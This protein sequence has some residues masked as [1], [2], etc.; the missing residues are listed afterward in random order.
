MD[1]KKWRLDRGLTQ[2]EAARLIGLTG[3]SWGSLE[4]GDKKLQPGELDV[5][6]ALTVVY[7]SGEWDE[8]NAK[9]IRPADI[10]AWRRKA[11][12][13]QMEASKMIGCSDAQYC[14][15]ENGKKVISDRYRLALALLVNPQAQ[16]AQDAYGDKPDQACMLPVAQ[17]TE[18]LTIRSHEDRHV[19]TYADIAAAYQV[20]ESLVRKA[21]SNNSE[22]WQSSRVKNTQETYLVEI[23]TDSGPRWVRVF[24]IRGASR[25]SFHLRSSRA[26]QVQDHCLDLLTAEVEAIQQA[27]SQIETDPIDAQI[28]ALQELKDSKRRIARLEQRFVEVEQAQAEIKFL[29]VSKTDRSDVVGIVQEELRT[30]AQEEAGRI[31]LRKDL[32]A[33]EHEVVWS[34]VNS[35]GGAFSELIKDLR[36]QIRRAIIGARS[37]KSWGRELY[38]KSDYTIAYCVIELWLAAHNARPP[39]QEEIDFG[40]AI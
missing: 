20:D 32:E 4:R 30:Q 18:Y 38:Q 21:F 34:V 40:G 25:F 6:R 10:Q 26:E 33:R 35:H 5:I 22:R 24:T 2:T 7:D 1:Y 19:L 8:L 23:Q 39:K 37:V 17:T 9:V 11:G 29:E 13:T 28:L 3:P 31:M 16:P 12:K 14:V 15:M 36:N 27:Q